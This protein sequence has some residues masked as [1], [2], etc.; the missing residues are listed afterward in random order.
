MK[1]K[2]PSPLL[3]TTVTLVL[4]AGIGATSAAA[5]SG[6]RTYTWLLASDFL[7]GLAPDARGP[8]CPAISIAANGDTIELSGS[9]TLSIHPTAVSG[10]GVFT[11]TFVGGGSISGSWVATELLSFHSYGSGAAQGFP[12]DFEGG[13]ALVRVQLSVG[14]TPV[15][16]GVMQIDCTLGE[17]IPA[18]AEDGARLAVAG[19]LNFNEE[20]SGFTVFIRLP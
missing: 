2:V 10:G 13:L 15:A 12:P 5:D 8:A 1:Q 6:A 20:I 11:H 19:A 3:I 18:D 17:H 9:G 14:G 4:L 7:C 16:E